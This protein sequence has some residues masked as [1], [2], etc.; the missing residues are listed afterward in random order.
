MLKS[1]LVAFACSVSVSALA[2]AETPKSIDVPPGALGVALDLVSQQAGVELIFRPDQVAGLRTNGVMGVLS[3]RE[4][5]QKLLEGTQLQVRSDAATGAMMIGRAPLPAPPPKA[6]STATDE[7]PVASEATESKSAPATPQ[8]RGLL[9]TLQD[10]AG[11]HVCAHGLGRKR[12][13]SRGGRLAQAR[14]VPGTGARHRHAHP[15]H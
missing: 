5:V 10:R 11:G 7:S 2:V 4:A 12:R 14:S 8:R 1:G 6:D 3:A 13:R 9:V 15:R